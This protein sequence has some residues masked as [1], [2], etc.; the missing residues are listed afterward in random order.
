MKQYLKKLTS[1]QTFG[2]V[3]LSLLLLL[4]LLLIPTGYEGALSYQ[5]A[6]RVKALVL[7]TDESSII[8]TGLVRSGEQRCQVRILGG[9]FKG[10]EVEAVN[11]L[12]GS[13][14]EDKLFSEG[15][16]AF[17]VVSHSGGEITTVSMSDH[18]R[19]DKEALLAGLFLLLLILFAGSTGLRAILS[20][21]DTILL[22]WKVL[23]PSLLKGFN[24]VWVS[25]GLVLVLTA[26]VLSLIYGLDKRCLAAVSGAALAIG[27]TAILG[28][29]FT[30]LFQIH[31]AVMEYSES[32]LYSGYQYLDLNQIFVASIFLGSSGAVMDL[33]VD[34]CSAVH[35]VVLKKPDISAKE[36]IASGFAVGR[37]A[38]GSTTTT[39]L[40]AYSGSYIA[41][42]MVFMAQGTPVEML[43]NYKYVA[44]EIIHTIVGSFGLVTVAPL[45]AITSG[46]LLTRKKAE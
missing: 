32:L 9:Q 41:L 14:A 12:N 22:M 25:L 33:S 16:Y 39:L 21:I 8:D 15:D 20:F 45:T 43:L 6:D 36:A 42:L 7:S 24:P 10:Q 26:L 3:L 31:G 17:V 18:Y 34:I 37:A 44:A 40:L 11:R 28:Y 29:L 38:C 23:V 46:L 19:L 1:R 5:N 4:V 13:L 35:E 2:P 30:D 27:V